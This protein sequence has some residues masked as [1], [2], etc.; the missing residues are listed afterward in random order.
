MRL[1]RAFFLEGRLDSM[2]RRK[3]ERWLC[4]VVVVSVLPVAVPLAAW[5]QADNSATIEK[6]STE[7]QR[8]LVSGDFATAEAAYEK[9]REL[10]PGTAEIHVNL[11]LIYY[12]ERKFQPAVAELRRGLKLN[13]NLQKAQ[14]LLAM[15]LSELGQYA[16]ALPLLEKGFRLAT[17]PAIKRSCGLHL[18]RAY[19]G[20]GRDGKAVEVGLELARLYPNDP[21][22]LYHNGR[23]FGNFA[24]LSIKHLSDVAPD[25]IWKHQAAAEAY[26]SQGSYDFAIAEYRQVLALDPHRPGIHYRLGRSLLA[27]GQQSNS[28][29]AAA[30]AAKE[31]AAELELDPTNAN[32]AYELGEQHRSEGQMVDAESYFRLAVK[33]YPDFEQAN[34]GLAAV[35][36]KE[37][38]PEAARDF[39]RRALATNPSGEVG[40]YRMGQIE[41]ALGNA[42]GQEKA[43]AEFQRLRRRSNAT[44]DAKRVVSPDEVTP[45]KTDE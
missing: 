40:W 16:E 12:S 39:A 25:S 20:L 18:E 38:K 33:Y 1:W 23:L 2:I 45:Q 44:E 42:A 32:A 9:L 17:D 21:E 41:R 22:V 31:F 6:Y 37:G 36:L 26:E 14:P 5:P 30:E 7:G 24:Y 19:T 4:G 34:L 15:S 29:D 8:A 35:L 13:P 43:V 28:K 27:R 11:G 3:C 10:S